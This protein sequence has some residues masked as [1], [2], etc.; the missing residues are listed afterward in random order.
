VISRLSLRAQVQATKAIAGCRDTERLYETSRRILSIEGSG[1]L[2]NHISSLIR[3]IYN[4]Q[5]VDLFDAPPAAM[6][7]SGA[8]PEEA[9][10]KT[11]QAYFVD[12]DCFDAAT[13][14]WHCVLR[15]G[16]PPVGGLALHGT[17][18]NKLAVTALASLCATAL[19]RHRVLQRES[20]AE[21]VRQMEQLRTAVLDALAHQFKTPLA[22]ARTASSGLLAI[23][24]LSELQTDL[25][26]SIDRQ[27]KKLDHLASRLLTAARLEA[28]EFKPRQ[29]ALL[30]SRVPNLAIQQLDQDS[31]R[32]RFRVSV[33]IREKPVLADQELILTSVAQ[34]VTNAIQYSEPRSAI[35]VTFMTEERWVILKVRS[36]GLVVTPTECERI[37]PNDFIE[38]RRPN[39]RQLARGWPAGPW[40][41]APAFRKERNSPPTSVMYSRLFRK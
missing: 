27:A 16:A 24:G 35:D 9:E 32:A 12:E 6:Y 23:G 7:R 29:E 18:M 33:P 14:S 17:T 15:F 4:L 40:R 37:V 36:K 13:G 26:T 25:V 22:I 1:E 20:H 8:G 11:R 19:E 30:F 2:G 31:D 39:M 21:V 38:R 34:L 41:T 3:E 5:A 10:Y 28:A